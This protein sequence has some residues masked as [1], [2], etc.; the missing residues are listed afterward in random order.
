[1]ENVLNV[2]LVQLALVHL[3]T[4]DI[5]TMQ[6]YVLYVLQIVKHAQVL[7]L[8]QVVLHI[9]IFQVELVFIKIDF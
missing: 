3:V 6:V 4:L 7:I 1:M 8:A 2:I 9:I 5:I